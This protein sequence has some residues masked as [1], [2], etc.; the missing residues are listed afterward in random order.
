LVPTLGLEL[1]LRVMVV[2]RAA[3]G[4]VVGGN[5]ILVKRIFEQV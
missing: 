2:V 5:M 1:E 4:V 3:V